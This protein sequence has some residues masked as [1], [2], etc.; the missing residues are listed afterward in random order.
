MSDTKNEVKTIKDS[1][2]SLSDKLFTYVYKKTERVVAAIYLVTSHMSENEPMK[3]AI[4]RT[5]LSLLKDII[6]AGSTDVSTDQ[7]SVA[8]I[9]RSMFEI[10]SLIECSVQSGL[11]SD[12]N[13]SL[14][15]DEVLQLINK[16]EETRFFVK[17]HR[18]SSSFFDVK[19]N[20][21]DVVSSNALQTQA[22]NQFIERGIFIKDNDKNIK[23]IKNYS[24]SLNTRLGAVASNAN[25]QGSNFVLEDSKRHSNRDDRRRRIIAVIK[26]SKVATIKDVLNDISDLGEKTIQRELLAMVSDGVLRKE[27][28]R[29]WSRY[30]LIS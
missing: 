30:S 10:I 7:K 8:I 16:I 22:N 17:D 14:I 25:G 24:P 3:E 29:R 1:Q 13:A 23:D 11:V 9:S 15:R 5:S 27:G 20:E 12:M 4:R 2:I 6:K 18:L 19:L 26:R 28:E 21:S